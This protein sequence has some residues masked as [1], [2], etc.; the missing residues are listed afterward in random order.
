[1]YKLSDNE[2]DKVLSG[3]E[4]CDNS[5]LIERIRNIDLYKIVYNTAFIHGKHLSR[6]I[7][8]KSRVSEKDENVVSLRMLD[9]RDKT[10]DKNYR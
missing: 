5:L 1:M 10:D 6:E 4:I 2:N 3:D 7:I 9:K 8:L